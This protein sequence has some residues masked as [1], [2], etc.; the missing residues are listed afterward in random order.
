MIVSDL[1]KEEKQIL[2][3]GLSQL[4]YVFIL[5]AISIAIFL[6][7]VTHVLNA[8]QEA[9]IVNSRIQLTIFIYG[10]VFT[11]Y[12]YWAWIKFRKPLQNIL[13]GKKQFVVGIVDEKKIHTKWSWHGGVPV[14]FVSRPKLV[15]Y[16]LVIETEQ[17][18]VEKD[19]YHAIEIGDTMELSFGYPNRQ[20]ILMRTVPK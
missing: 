13:S 2:L 15:E 18:F 3:S 7:M 6:V 14:D 1:T 11:I 16:L 9:F 12:G 8:S 4:V 20:V 17:Y 19:F 5:I 10:L